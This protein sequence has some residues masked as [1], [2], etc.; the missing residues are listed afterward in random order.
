MT[1]PLRS[2]S[3]TAPPLRPGPLTPGERVTVAAATPGAEGTRVPAGSAL[4]GAPPS[5]QAR[6]NLAAAL[7]A[8]GVPVEEPNLLAA[9]A[10]VRFGLPI[11][12]ENLSDVR[13]VTA[14]RMIR[15]PETVALA[16]SLGLPVTSPAILRALDTLLSA[17]TDPSLLTIAVSVRPN[18]EA[19]A[20]HLQMAARASAQSV[21]NKLLTGDLDGARGDL[22][23]YLLRQSLDGDADC[24]AAARHLEGQML[25]SAASSRN[26]DGGA[27]ASPSLLVAFVAATPGGRGQYVEMN[28]RP[29]V[30]DEENE[31]DN[32]DAEPGRQHGGTRGTAA[33]LHL[34]TANLGLVTAR[35]FLDPSGRL[36][37][38]LAA[39]DPKGAARIERGLVHLENAF[40]HAGFADATAR[41]TSPA[42]ISAPAPPVEASR[43]LAAKP[44]RALDLRA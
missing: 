33:S 13:R 41:V 18:T 44:L 19:M 2:T 34:P 5:T 28:L 10:L 11:T 37:C 9:Q 20:D 31:S 43:A 12:L 14:T 7:A 23:S 22:R 29:N 39:N 26:G 42:A 21:E 17:R 40:T 4:A 24:E 30:T 36:T 8:L 16:K 35:L 15:L 3:A 6:Q 1:D 38:R 32:D 27:A 25:V